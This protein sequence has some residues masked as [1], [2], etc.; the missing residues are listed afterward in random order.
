MAISIVWGLAFATV[1][2]LVMVP[3]VLAILDDIGA[4]LGVRVGPEADGEPL[5]TQVAR[6]MP[7]GR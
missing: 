5:E 3:C 4:R 7:T 1:L 6:A 2:T